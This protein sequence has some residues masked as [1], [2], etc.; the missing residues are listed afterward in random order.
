MSIP[1]PPQGGYQQQPQPQPYGQQGPYGPPPPQ[2]GPYAPSPQGPYGPPQG[3]PPGAPGPFPYPQQQQPFPPFQPRPPKRKMHPALIAVLVLVGLG[4]LGTVVRAATTASNRGAGPESSYPPAEHKLDLPKSLLDGDYD[5]GQDLSSA[6][7]QDDGTF[8]RDDMKDF[9]GV[10]AQYTGKNPGDMLVFSGAYGRIRNQE[11]MRESVL[12]GAA[13]GDN[14]TL[15]VPP[16]DIV[17]AGSGLTVSCQV[18]SIDN[19]T[20]KAS[21]PMCAWADGNTGGVVAESTA[22]FAKQAPEDVDLGKVAERTL[23]VREE[24]RKPIS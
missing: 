10:A 8:S 23:Q 24:M 14:A 18:L 7:P 5:L 19:G 3:P 15:A 4:I 20:A 11:N 16:K 13:K 6:A 2:Q 12:G 17:P 21:T 1:T 22:E 9:T